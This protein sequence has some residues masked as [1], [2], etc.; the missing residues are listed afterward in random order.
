MRK[1]KNPAAVATASG[2]GGFDLAER[3]IGPVN[4][5]ER[6]RLQDR[7]LASPIRI[8]VARM[9]HGKWRATLNGRTL[10]TAAAPMVQAARILIVN[11]VDSS[12]VIEMW[13]QHADAWA[14]RGKL[15]AVAAT[16]LDGERKAQRHTRNR[17]LAPSSG[18]AAKSLTAGRTTP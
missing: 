5:T 10:C 6:E 11:G 14:L 3:Q 13:H 1:K 2:G 16:I 12:S 4:T 15:S 9:G 18:K 17:P 7:P 8:D